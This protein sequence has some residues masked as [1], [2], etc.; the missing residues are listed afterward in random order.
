MP[1]RVAVLNSNVSGAASTTGSY[2]DTKCCVYMETSII[3]HT[4]GTFTVAKQGRNKD[5]LWRHI[6]PLP[7]TP[8]SMTTT[9]ADDRRWSPRDILHETAT[10]NSAIDVDIA[11]TGI[12]T[13]E[14][15]SRHTLHRPRH[16]SPWQHI[17]E[18]SLAIT[19]CELFI[20]AKLV[21]SM[22]NRL[23]CVIMKDSY[24]VTELC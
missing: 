12:P 17:G 1:V 7:A 9:I 5:I 2:L 13:N 6:P 15:S 21:I 14:M 24:I 23:V 19:Q 20:S 16:L 11:M 8:N 4:F 10:A 18:T 3:M 22:S